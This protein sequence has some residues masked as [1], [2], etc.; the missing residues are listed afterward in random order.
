MPAIE[1]DDLNHLNVDGLFEVYPTFVET[2]TFLGETI[3][4]MELY[5]PLLFFYQSYQ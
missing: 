1:Q 3:M 5:Y 2:G 4:K